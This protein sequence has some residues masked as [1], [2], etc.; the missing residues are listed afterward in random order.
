M[1]IEVLVLYIQRVILKNYR[2]YRDL[3]IQLNKGINIFYGQNAQGK[4]NII[5]SICLA[6]TGKSHRT[7]KDA[8]L[9][10]W[11]SEDSRVKIEFEKEKD[12]KTVE[13][14]LRKGFK[15]QVKLNGVRLN[16]IGE[17]I[18]NLNTVV[19]S[20]DHMK[21]IKDG[22]SERRRFIDIILSQV[23]PGYYYN[24]VQYLKVLEQRNILLNEAQKNSKAINTID[25]WNEQLVLYGTK[26]IKARNEFIR[27]INLFASETHERISNGKEK[28]E[29]IY[30][31]SVEA[32]EGNEKAIEKK[33]IDYLERFRDI[34]IKRGITHKGPHRDDLFLYLNNMEVK[35]YCSQGQQR[36][37]LLSLKISELKYMSKETEEVPVLLL[38]D[39]FSELDMER[40]KYLM[41][42]IKGVQTVITCTDIEHMDKLKINDTELF[43]VING[44]VY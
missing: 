22:P 38:D 39:V 15:K 11:N 6:S 20:P 26:I 9:I 41:E 8:E 27:N 18:G 19:F 14:Y 10:N 12:N 24:L 29:I 5:E 34:D 28:L 44:T 13:I 16:K 1:V 2:N 7:Q 17:L 31:P 23:K 43:K 40:Q 4:T 32:Y 37:T 33:Y 21:I 25:I 30:K 3:N 42:F 35:T 36:T